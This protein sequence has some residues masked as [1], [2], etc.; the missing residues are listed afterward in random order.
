[1]GVATFCC[2]SSVDVFEVVRTDLDFY[3]FGLC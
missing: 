3:T 1:M 2:H